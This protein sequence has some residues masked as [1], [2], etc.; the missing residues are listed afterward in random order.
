MQNWQCGATVMILKTDDPWALGRASEAESNFLPTLHHT[1][2]FL[3]FTC[4][5]PWKL[6]NQISPKQRHWTQGW[7]WHCDACEGLCTGYEAHTEHLHTSN[8][9]MYGHYAGCTY[10]CMHMLNPHQHILYD[11]PE[12]ANTIWAIVKDQDL[13]Q[14]NP[15]LFNAWYLCVI[16]HKLSHSFKNTQNWFWNSRRWP[17]PLARAMCSA[18]L[19]IYCDAFPHNQNMHIS[20]D[21]RTEEQR[22]IE[23]VYKV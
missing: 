5:T 2:C 13:A 12:A 18:S 10:I 16:P 7:E 14:N 1:K 3:L 9:Y 8:C 11:H 15:V 23:C 21:A 4:F 22:S 17:N 20:K 6:I 19:V